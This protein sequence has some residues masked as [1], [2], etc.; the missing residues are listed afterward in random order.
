MLLMLPL[1][2][3]AADEA[4]AATMPGAGLERIPYGQRL[5][6]RRFTLQESS[7]RGSRLTFLTHGLIG[8]SSCWRAGYPVLREVAGVIATFCKRRWGA[9]AAPRSPAACN[10]D[11]VEPP[12]IE[13][14]GAERYSRWR[15]R[16]RPSCTC[17]L[18]AFWPG[19]SSLIPTSSSSRA[20]T[21][22]RNA[23]G[24]DGRQVLRRHGGC[25][26]HV[27][28]RPHHGLLHHPAG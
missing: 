6:Q 22:G 3:T 23:P 13:P 7:L 5:L 9:P 21:T 12:G 27:P 19:R 14:P 11:R 4:Q 2:P 26:F 16:P 17:G 25:E 10:R 8:R 20:S 28:Q 1:A 24:A 15:W 18:V